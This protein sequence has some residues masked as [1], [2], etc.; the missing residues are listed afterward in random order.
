MFAVIETGGKQ[1][2]VHQD[3]VYKVEKLAGNIGDKVS[4][5]QVLM[6]GGAENVTTVGAPFIKDAS[7]EVEIVEQMKDKKVIVFKKQR[8]QHYRRKKGHRQQV[9]LVKVTNIH[10]K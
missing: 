2:R 1:Y 10:N 5:D 9:T 3:G 7:V 6:L 8:R 4:F